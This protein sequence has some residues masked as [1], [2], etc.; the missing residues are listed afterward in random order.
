MLRGSYTAT[1]DAKG[2]LKIPAAFKALIDEKY[3]PEFYITSM[4]G[5]SARIYP[6]AEWRKIEEKLGALPSMKLAMKRLLDRT[7]LW[8]QMARMDG[9]GRVLVPP[10]LREAAGVR[11]EVKVLGYLHYMDVWNPERFM[12]H[13]EQDPL[14]SE[15]LETL[16]GL[17]I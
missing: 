1:V 15:D 10:Q 7:N 16:S 2:R 6:L 5:Q 12:E 3:G 17:N 9:Q 13:L 8:G 11:G 14:T 4:D